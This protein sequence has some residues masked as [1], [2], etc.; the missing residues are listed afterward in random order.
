MLGLF[1]AE[2]LG[3][4]GS[5]CG[6][7]GLIPSVMNIAILGASQNSSQIVGISCFCICT[8]LAAICLGIL[9]VLNGNK[10]YQTYASS[11]TAKEKLLS[12]KVSKTYVLH[13]VHG[14]HINCKFDIDS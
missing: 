11:I 12:N 5:G 4:M 9:F 8:S 2:Y 7:G 10:F 6:I 14:L 1:P 13:G 3:S